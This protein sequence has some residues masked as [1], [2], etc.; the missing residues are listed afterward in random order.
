M[1]KLVVN[2]A[3]LKCSE[4][5]APSTLMVVNPQVTAGMMNAA[6]IMDYIPMVNILPFG[7][8]KS[9]A[10]PTVASATSAAMGVLTPMPCIPAV[11]APWSSGASKTQVRF[12]PALTDSCKCMCLW[13]GQIEVTNP[14]QQS[15]EV[16]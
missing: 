2:A 6:N 15:V 11:V 1:A 7:M 13:A 10:N 3:M 5:L 16:G 14:G 8:C 9:M 12:L 4:G